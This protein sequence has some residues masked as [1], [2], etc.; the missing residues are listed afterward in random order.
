MRERRWCFEID[1]ANNP[2]DPMTE[3]NP[4]IFLFLFFGVMLP[5]GLIALAI[6]H[7]K[8]NSASR[9]VKLFWASLLTIGAI[10]LVCIA[11]V[12]VLFVAANFPFTSNVVTHTTGPGGLE[13]CVVQTFKGAEPYQVSLYVHRPGEPWVWHYLAHQDFRWRDSRIDFTN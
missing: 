7:L 10:P 6:P 12:L 9:N 1:K 3:L 4:S 2:F 13:A 11:F 8:D 5:I